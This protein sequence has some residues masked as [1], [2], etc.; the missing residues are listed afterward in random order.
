MRVAILADTH[1]FLDPRIRDHVSHCDVAIHAGD[2]GG[3]DVLLAMQPREEV[4]AIRGN[5]DTPE[6]WPA[7]EHQ[8]LA[9]LPR[10]ASVELPG[11]LLIVVHG[12]DPATL[13]ER[14]SRYRQRYAHARAV[15]YGH[16]HRLLTDFGEQPWILNPGAAGRTR[17]YGGP[18]CLFIDCAPLGWRVETLRLEPR[19]YPSIRNVPRRS[20]NAH[21]PRERN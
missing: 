10:E 17:T 11:G 5:N 21:T 15:V 6:K 16:S 7:A 2:I 1:G 20:I 3:A 4:V 19:K 14:H 13:L 8:L 12:D 18:S 9:T